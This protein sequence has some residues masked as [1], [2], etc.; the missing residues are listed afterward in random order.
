MELVFVTESRFIKN[1]KGEY[2]GGFSANYNLWE[3]YLESFD[4]VMI[5]AR[6]QYIADYEEDQQ[7]LSSGTSVDFIDIPYYIGPFEFL[8]K[9]YEIHK[10]IKSN[11]K[12]NNTV[13]ICRIPGNIGNIAIKYLKQKRISYG[14]EVVGDPWDVFAPGSIMHPLR[15]YFR[16]KGYLDLKQNVYK[17]NA[18]LYVTKETLQ[19][20]YPVRNN[21]FQVGVSDVKIP[22][23]LFTSTRTKRNSENKM[24]TLISVGS[25]QQMY[26]SPDIVLEALKKLINEGVSCQLIWLGD[27]VFRSKME[28]LAR[29][30]D[31]EE[32]VLFKGNVSS[33]S[34]RDYLLQSDI[35]VLASRTEGLPRAVVEAMAAGL[36]CIGTKVG[37]IPELLEEIVLIP[38][39]D[40]RALCQKVKDLIQNPDFY[41]EQARR[42]LLESKKYSESV[43]KEKR[44]SFYEYLID[45]KR[46]MFNT[47]QCL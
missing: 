33:E 25:L 17:S 35:F 28:G 27:G 7:N 9:R 22:D 12:N 21:A 10:V 43:L 4:R 32:Y 14:V 18:A 24:Y 41:N 39:E 11:I 46:L 34:V 45:K 19:Q 31:I 16:I 37:G 23:E 1:S 15:F 36:P 26:K 38:K 3:R 30:L 6:V 40:S 29:E 44:T 42:N 13:Y 5:M 47:L 20:R 8:K 2:Y